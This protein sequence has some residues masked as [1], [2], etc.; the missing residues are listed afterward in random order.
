[1]IYVPS[2]VDGRIRVYELLPSNLMHHIDTIYID[3]PLDNVSPDANGDL[4]VAGF[5][6]GL[7]AAKGFAEVGANVPA[8]IFRVRKTVDAGPEGVR[9]VDYR[10]EK[11]L[12][13]REGT[14]IGGAT[15]VR[16]DSKTGRL[17]VGGEF[18]VFF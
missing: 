2:S 16:H 15:T 14:T 18:I 7:A 6:D 17:F 10:V 12:E 4:W 1:L 9:S 13:D 5:P 11:M 3:M 8:S